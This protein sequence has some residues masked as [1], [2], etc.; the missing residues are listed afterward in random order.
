MWMSDI[1]MHADSMLLG[2]D[3]TSEKGCP[4]WKA[5]SAVSKKLMPPA[6]AALKTWLKSSCRQQRLELIKCRTEH[7]IY[8]Q[9]TQLSRVGHQEIS[10]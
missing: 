8:L 4:G 10:Q 9:G 3:W 7:L 1:L 2:S 6:T 5:T